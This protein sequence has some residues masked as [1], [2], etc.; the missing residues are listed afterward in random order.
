[1]GGTFPKEV[2]QSRTIEVEMELSKCWSV[3]E[4][5]LNYNGFYAIGS[6]GDIFHTAEEDYFLSIWEAPEECN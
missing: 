2:K 4:L 1:M 5:G 3:N 6:Y